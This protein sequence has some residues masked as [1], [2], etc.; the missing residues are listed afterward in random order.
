MLRQVRRSPLFSALI[1]ILLAIG[2][3]AN[4]LVFSLVNELLLRPLPVRDPQNLYRIERNRQLQVRPDV[5]FDYPDYRDVILKSDLF[6]AAVAEEEV[7]DNIVVPVSAGNEVRMATTQIVSPNYFAELGIQPAAGRVLAPDDTD[8]IVISYQFW[9]SHF[10]GR[11]DIVGQPLRVNGASFTIAGILPKEFH[12]SDIDRAPDIRVPIGASRVLMGEDVN[13]RRGRA[14]FRVLARLAP[15]ITREHASAALLG[16]LKAAALAVAKPEDREFYTNFQLAFEPI[17]R[18]VSR[19]RDQFSRALW[20]LLGGVGLLLLAVCA[21]VAGLLIAKSTGRRREM[22]IRLAIGASRAQLIRQLLGE[23]LLLAIPGAILGALL[24][25]STA[26]SLIHLLPPTRDYARYQSPQLLT[27]QPDLKVLAFTA[28]LMLFCVLAFGLVPAWRG[29]SVSLTAEMRAAARRGHRSFAA[30]A[31]VGLQ[32]AFCVLLVSAAGLMLR[33]FWKLDHTDPGFYRAHIIEF[34]M[35]TQSPAFYRELIRRAGEI[36]GVRSVSYAGMGLMRGIGMKTTIAPRGVTLP[37]NTFLNTS[38]NVVSPEYF[39]TM[40]MPILAG[41]GLAS[42]DFNHKP[43]QIVVNQAFAD[44][45]FPHKNPI[46]EILT[47]KQGVVAD[48]EIVGLFPTA[49]YRNMREPDPPIYYT[50]MNPDF[51]SNSPWLLY[52]RTYGKPDSIANA[53]RSIVTALDPSVPIVEQFTIEQE[54]QTTMWQE[55]LVAILS[56]FFG[57]TAAALAAIGMYGTLT[58]SVTQ[59]THELGIRVAIGACI[60]HVVQTVCSPIAA[61]VAGGIITGLIGAAL[62]LRITERLLYGIRATDPITLAA[63][64][65]FV[66]ICGALAAAIPSLR[67]VRIDPSRALREE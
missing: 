45:F 10:A 62:L 55:R 4:T 34:S 13:N 28:V 2:I 31:P 56:A 65:V 32:I 21:N 41:R 66:A 42:S 58:Y 14:R 22:A 39:A 12:S 20:L 18:G 44:T 35:N 8:A 25:Y 27:V 37:P 57:L 46:A 47:R 40:G 30:V 64:V 17:G 63:T 43:D 59:R 54:I 61:A 7:Y 29:A 24:A 23:Y 38:V 15:G 6:S 5:D 11:R 67:A 16:P 1:V 52:L 19:L 36:P 50:V 33:T 9:Q 49:K 53:V 48:F 26:P 60:R 3:G 51:T